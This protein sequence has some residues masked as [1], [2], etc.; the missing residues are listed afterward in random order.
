MAA[1]KMAENVSE[2]RDSLSEPSLTSPY[3]FVETLSSRAKLA[4]RDMVSWQLTVRHR[5][6]ERE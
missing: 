1:D 4:F 3:R 2:N 6:A 5:G